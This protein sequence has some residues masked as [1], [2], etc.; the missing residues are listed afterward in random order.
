MDI[1]FQIICIMRVLILKIESAVNAL[2]A[3]IQIKRNPTKH[4]SINKVFYIYF[5]LC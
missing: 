3:I 4:K 5:V 2:Q 1:L